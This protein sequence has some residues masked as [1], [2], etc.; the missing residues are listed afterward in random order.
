MRPYVSERGGSPFLSGE[1]SDRGQQV[2]ETPAW[3]AV[4]G[5]QGMLRAEG[6]L[7]AFLRGP[8]RRCPCVPTIRGGHVLSEP[9]S[10]TTRSRPP[11]GRAD[12]WAPRVPAR[13]GGPRDERCTQSPG[14]L[15]RTAPQRRSQRGHGTRRSLSGVCSSCGGSQVAKGGGSYHQGH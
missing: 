7:P 5:G 14:R 9:S 8:Q 3:R 11:L 10:V 2:A 13:P 12:R 6:P 4:S 15:G 1:E